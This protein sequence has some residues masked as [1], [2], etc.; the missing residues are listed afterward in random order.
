MQFL[1]VEMP[2]ARSG[3]LDIDRL[4]SRAKATF[5]SVG[6]DLKKLIPRVKRVVVRGDR[7]VVTLPEQVHSI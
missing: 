3:K 7:A 5:K 6:T 1:H 2:Q 4:G